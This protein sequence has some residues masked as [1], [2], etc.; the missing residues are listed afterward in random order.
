MKIAPTVIKGRN[1]KIEKDVVIW[2]YVVILN[3]VEIKSG[4]R[5]GSF[6]DIGRRA[7]IGRNGSIQAHVTLADDTVIGDNV[8][9]GPGTSFFNGKY[10]PQGV[11]PCIVE[12]DAIIGGQCSIIACRVG[13]GAVIGAGSVVTRHV[14]E[15]T[16]VAGNPAR[17]LYDRKNFEE[18]RRRWLRL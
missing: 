10:P 17:F 3:D 7:R 2:N 15:D 11:R 4:T 12:D 13:K 6:C 18:K 14:P 1:V 9:V 16:V 5:I 8:F